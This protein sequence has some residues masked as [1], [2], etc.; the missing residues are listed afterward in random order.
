MS[1][2]TTRISNS[3][4]DNW[5]KLIKILRFVHCTLKGNIFGATNLDEIFK[6][7]DASY[8]VHHDMKSHTG[9]VIYMGLGVYSL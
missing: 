9:G 3:H 7:V 6:W 4:D 1:F 5:G 8:A 2:L